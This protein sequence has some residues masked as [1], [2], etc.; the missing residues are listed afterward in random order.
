M[1][2][3]KGVQSWLSRFWTTFIFQGCFIIIIIIII[4]NNNNNTFIYSHI[5]KL[6]IV[7]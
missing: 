3:Y 5:L 4:N 1:C 2:I 6:T 7:Y